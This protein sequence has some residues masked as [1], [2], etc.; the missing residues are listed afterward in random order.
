V[1]RAGAVSEAAA[2]PLDTLAGLY[3]EARFSSHEMSRGDIWVARKALQAIVAQ[4][5]PEGQDA[6]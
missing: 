2:R 5:H 1:L 4:L 6:R 3:R